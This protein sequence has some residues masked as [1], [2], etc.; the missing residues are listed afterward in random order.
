MLPTF[1]DSSPLL[2]CELLDTQS[3]ITLNFAPLQLAEVLHW[4]PS[5]HTVNLFSNLGSGHLQLSLPF[6]IGAC[7][8]GC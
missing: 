7:D 5:R 4:E 2:N 8:P 1:L 6:A 3:C